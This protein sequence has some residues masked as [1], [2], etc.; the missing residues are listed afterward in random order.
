MSTG[1]DRKLDGVS[2]LPLLLEEKPLGRRQ[3]FW[4]G[5]AMRDGPWKLVTREKSLEG[6]PALFNLDKDIAET[7]NL[8]AVHPQRVK[9]MIEALGAWTR[10]VADGQTPQ[11]DYQRFKDQPAR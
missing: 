2:L 7:T 4:N 5:V 10:D 11:P 3:L 6:G 9:R 8:A 1:Q